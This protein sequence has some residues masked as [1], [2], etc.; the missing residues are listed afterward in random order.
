MPL[1][2]VLSIMDAVDKE[3]LFF[4]YLQNSWHVLYS[5]YCGCFERSLSLFYSFVIECVQTARK[6]FESELWMSAGFLSLMGRM[7]KET[8][9]RMISNRNLHSRH[10]SAGPRGN[11]SVSIGKTNQLCCISACHIC[12]YICLWSP[13]SAYNPYDFR[14]VW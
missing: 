4:S 9:G 12:L 7:L 2:S 8:S 11:L 6:C 13:Q 5:P 1:Y 14:W 10:T 3:S